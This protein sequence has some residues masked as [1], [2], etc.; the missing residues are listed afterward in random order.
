LSY[1]WQGNES[2]LKRINDVIIQNILATSAANTNA[3]T[4]AANV[5]SASVT[6]EG[7]KWGQIG[8]AVLGMN[9]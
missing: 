6:A 4:N 2:S 1:T 5:Q 3:A 7:T 8:A 9:W